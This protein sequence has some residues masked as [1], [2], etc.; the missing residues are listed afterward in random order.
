MSRIRWAKPLVW[1]GFAAQLLLSACARDAKPSPTPAQV[2]ARLEA[3]KQAAVQRLEAQ[4]RQEAQERLRRRR[5]R[6]AQEF[7]Q[8]E[9]EHAAALAVLLKWQSAGDGRVELLS[10]TLDQ[11]PLLPTLQPLVEACGARLH[12]LAD[13]P[14]GPGTPAELAGKVRSQC[15]LAM[16]AQA[17]AQ[18]QMLAQLKV[19]LGLPAWYRD[20]GT[21]YAQQGKVSWHQWLELLTLEQ[22]YQERADHL[23]E[24]AAAVELTVPAAEH[25][26]PGLQARAVVIQQMQALQDRLGLP[27]GLDDRRLAA[28]VKAAWG[29]AAQLG[30]LAGWRQAPLQVRALDP[31]WQALVDEKGRTSRKLREFAALVPVQAG[32]G[33]QVP[34][35]AQG[36]W[37]LWGALE[38]RSGGTVLRWGDDLRRT[39]CPGAA[40]AGAVVA[41]L[42]AERR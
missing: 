13:H 33:L 6:L 8:L 36:C 40:K 3:E 17:I 10:Q 26:A 12:E 5:E 22:D 18:R 1:A 35:W 29:A 27:A 32:P 30:P 21:R 20:I 37:V 28:Q 16:R 42:G 39:R 4:R 15:D 14:Q 41:L 11:L 23:R 31:V 2:Q 25:L 24:A 19:L 9:R 38:Q 34:T 7:A